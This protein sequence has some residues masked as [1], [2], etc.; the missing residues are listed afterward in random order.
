MVTHSCILA[1][2]IPRTEDPGVIESGMTYQ[3][4]NNIKNMWLLFLLIY[5]IY[6]LAMPCGMQDLS[7]L[8]RDRTHTP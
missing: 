8:T 3:L 6:F 1:Q 7:P 2:R 5:L 4:N